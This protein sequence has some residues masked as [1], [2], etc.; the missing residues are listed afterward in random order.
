M[1]NLLK[2]LTSQMNIKGLVITAYILLVLVFS[3]TARAELA[4]DPVLGGRPSVQTSDFV[5]QVAMTV[6]QDFYLVVSDEE[7]YVLEAN[8]DLSD[9]NGQFVQVNGVKVL[10][11]VEPSISTSTVDPL[12]RGDENEGTTPVIVVLGI[13]GLAN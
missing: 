12:P 8:I 9:Y 7:F 1:M 2:K 5:G 4:I 10:P 3:A 13:S 11:K 6:N